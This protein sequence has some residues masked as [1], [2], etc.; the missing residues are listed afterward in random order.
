MQV[1]KKSPGEEA[2]I[3]GA[4]KERSAKNLKY[5]ND[6]SLKSVEALLFKLAGIYYRRVVELGIGMELEDVVQEMRLSYVKARQGWNPENGTLFSTY[7]ANVCRNNFNHSILKLER[8][9]TIGKIEKDKDGNPPKFQREFGMMSDC[10]FETEGGEDGMWSIIDQAEG[11]DSD[12]PDYRLD[13]AAAM[14]ESLQGLSLSGKRLIGKLLRSQLQ[15]QQD[16]QLDVAPKLRALAADA[17]LKGA[18]LARVK[19]EIFNR[20]GVKWH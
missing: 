4:V 15:A 16:A 8:Q 17:G 13:R 14:S 12:R 2:G 6:G 9:R 20:F 5:G 1:S 3:S 18:E 19:L 11:R 7:C 10:E